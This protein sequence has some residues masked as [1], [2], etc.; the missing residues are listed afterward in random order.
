ME[1]K[2]TYRLWL[3]LRVG[4]ALAT[5]E[6]ALT[7]S[8]AGRELVIESEGKSQPLSEAPWLLIGCRGFEAEDD[9]RDFGEKLRRAAHMAGLCARVGVDAGDPGEDRTVSW[10]NPNI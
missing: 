4:K 5:E 3:K 6:T 8:I 9:A 7:A 2:T 1:K 10:I